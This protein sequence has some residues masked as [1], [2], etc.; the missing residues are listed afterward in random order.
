MTPQRPVIL[1]DIRGRTVVLSPVDNGSGLT[2][3]DVRALCTAAALEPTTTVRSTFLPVAQL[4]D[5]EAMCQHR[6]VV[7]Q[8]RKRW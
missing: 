4:P 8:R 1:A 5:L 3:A 2:V 6:G 7:V